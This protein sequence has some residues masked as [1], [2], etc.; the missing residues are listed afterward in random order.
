MFSSMFSKEDTN[1]NILRKNENAIIVN[2]ESVDTSSHSSFEEVHIKNN[3]RKKTI[4]VQ[5]IKI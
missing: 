5:M 3:I 2:D 1:N 4:C